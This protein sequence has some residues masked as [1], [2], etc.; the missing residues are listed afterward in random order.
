[1]IENYTTGTTQIGKYVSF[2]LY[3]NNEKI[4]AYLNSRHISGDKDSKGR[5]KPFFNIVT[6]AV[7][8]WYRATDIDRKNIEILTKK[9]GKTFEAFLLN[10]L[11]QDWMRREG[12]GQFLNDWGRSLVRYG[13]SVVKF[14][15]KG[16]RLHC[17][18][19][20]WNRLVIDTI[21]FNNGYKIEKLYLTVSQ[22]RQRANYDR[23]Q[24]ESLENAL[25]SREDLAGNRKD[26]MS[27]YVELYEVH[28]EMP[29]SYLTGK[30]ED[31]DTYVQQMHVVSYLAKSDGTV[32]DFTLFKGKEAR[33]PYMITHLIKEDGRAT[34]IGAVEHLFQAQWMVNHSILS[35]KNV[36]DVT[37]KVI[38]QTSDPSFTGKNAL[39]KIESGDIMVY[40]ENNPLTQINNTSND[41]TALQNFANQWK[42]I[43]Q[44]ITSTP[45]SLMGN[46][47]PS[48]TAW[49]QIEA[50]QTEAHSLFEI[51]VE[52]KGFYIEQMMKE[53]VIPFVKKSLSSK[54][55]VSVILDQNNIERIDT[56]Y[57]KSEA[58]RRANDKIVKQMLDNAGKKLE[59]MQ[60][61]EQPDIQAEMDTIQQSLSQ[62]GAQRFLKPS[63]IDEKTWK[64]VFKDMDEDV[65]INVTG[66]SVD[67]QNTVT[68]LTTVLKT[69]ATNPAILQDKN[70]K[71][72]FNKILGLTGSVSPLEITNSAPLNNS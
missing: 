47:A 51:M 46:T 28:G 69:I 3:E 40:K 19:I 63:E 24:V 16:D 67:I 64:E 65:I 41:I 60:V 21:D 68:T 5:D 15:E 4:D 13:S 55:E 45:D 42:A 25:K 59:D 37:S 6:S 72:I 35:I 44:E 17:E 54:K 31:D 30:E 48:G 14:I 58:I 22:L 56:M 26:N 43:G 11:V 10:L 1:M 9:S 34:G 39:T 32:D 12:F 49:R 18:V 70:A 33:D 36:V 71:L 53:Y 7:N 52:N 20:P 66:E 38:F 57:I 50:L 8:I 62:A 27:D 29:L 61:P 2:N 23:E